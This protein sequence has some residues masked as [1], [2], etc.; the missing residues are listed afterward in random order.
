MDARELKPDLS[1]SGYGPISGCCEHGNELYGSVKDGT[2]PDYP[3]DCKL[4]KE[5]S[6]PKEL[7]SRY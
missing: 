6:V 4:F 3:N 7:V 5:D 2:F 1:V